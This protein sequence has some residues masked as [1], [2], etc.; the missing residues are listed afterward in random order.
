[1]TY[2]LRTAALI[3]AVGLLAACSST[4]DGK[5]NGSSAPPSSATLSSAPVTSAQASTAAPT[6]VLPSSASTVAPSGL[7]AALL[8]PSD[9]GAD[10]TGKP[11][12]TAGNGS[13]LPCTPDKPPLR[14]Q[15][16][17][18][19]QAAIDFT[20][21]DGKLQV[22]ENLIGYGDDSTAQQAYAAATAGFACRSGKLGT[23][24]ITIS[25]AGKVTT[26]AAKI[27][28]GQGWDFAGG[29]V[30]G[31]AL[32]IRIGASLLAMTFVVESSA[33]QGGLNLQSIVDT[34]AR[35]LQAA[36]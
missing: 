17:P 10:Y 22:S 13:A 1:M 36:G 33:D 31:T 35:K 11:N 16:P 26:S 20:R 34:A 28:D 21:A 29:G 14:A 9:I 18:L 8:S 32:T 3:A 19:R 4:T 27:D 24:S 23:T 5:G 30:K 2:A 15:Y 12:T 25:A 6:P 7:D